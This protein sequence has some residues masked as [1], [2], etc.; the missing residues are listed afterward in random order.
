MNED[1]ILMLCE[2][3]KFALKRDRLYKFLM[4]MSGQEYAPGTWD[5]LEY[6]MSN[7]N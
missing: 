7:R 4:A 6:K 3:E 2:L 5:W 1:I